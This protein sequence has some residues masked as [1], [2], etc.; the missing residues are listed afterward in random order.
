MMGAAALV[1]ARISR[2]LPRYAAAAGFVLV[3][4]L[5]RLLLE[6]WLRDTHPYGA[7]YPA[8]FLVTYVLGRGP[9]V[10]AALL[11]GALGFW[12]FLAPQFGWGG[13]L[14]VLAPMLFFAVTAGAGIW[15][16][17][18]L[19]SALDSLGFEQERLKAIADAHAGLF[20][21]L[22][23]RIGHHMQLVAGVLV[24]SSR[25]EPD[26]EMVE[27]LRTAGERSQLIAR[28][29]RAFVDSP[30]EDI[31][32]I[33]FANALARAV[34]QETAQ[35]Y[36]RVQIVGGDV[37]LPSEMATSLG[38]ALVECLHLV[39][40]RKPSGVLR[41]A[42]ERRADEVRMS[43]SHTGGPG[44][45]GLGEASGLE[46]FCAIVEPLGATVTAR[47]TDDHHRGF[48]VALPIGTAPGG[49]RVPV[50]A[51]AP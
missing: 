1:T 20:K 15:L 16:I 45:D 8:V 39:L 28:A 30:E 26:P 51:A 46:L 42:L 29:H 19:T 33:P 5:L 48:D 25:G 11:S 32:F 43:L 37:L 41:I 18:V 3:V 36:D 6:P 24:L 7:F 22:Q 47:R 4:F 49:T 9:A 17:S 27:I 10:L 44:G 38:I 35:A 14:D 40:Q 34:C 31:D 21:D 13:G 2:F 23:S 12:A 50:R